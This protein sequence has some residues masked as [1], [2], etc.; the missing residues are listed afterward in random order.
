MKQKKAKIFLGLWGFIV[1][2]SFASSLLQAEESS[3]PLDKANIDVTDLP[4][5]QR[6]AKIFMNYCAGCHSLKFVRYNSLG[7]GIGIVDASGVLL[8]EAIKKNLMFVGDKITDTIQ[9]SMTNEEGAKWFG[10]DPPDLSL[11]ARSRGPDWLYTYLRSF[12]LDPKRPWGVNNTVFPDVAMPD[13][14]YYFRLQFQHE[15]GGQEKYDQAV[16]DLV[17]FLTYVGEPVQLIRKRIG[18]WVLLFLGVFFVFAYLLKREYW[19]DVH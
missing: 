10:I 17:N 15:K 5:L 14:L 7:E 8:E 19:K 13:A 18:I 9:R 1:L 3:V 16:L 2:L 4:S 11:V 12:Y 6:G